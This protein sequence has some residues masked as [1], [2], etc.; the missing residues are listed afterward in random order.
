MRVVGL[1]L[2]GVLALT[3]PSA[4]HA[5]GLGSVIGPANAGSAPGIVL[6]MGRRWFGQT[7]GG[8]RRPSD[9]RSHSTME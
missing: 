4:G 5:G 1:S 7:P 9:G 3:V 2:A 8:C 6:G